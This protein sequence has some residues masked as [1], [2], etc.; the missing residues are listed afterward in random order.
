MA[1]AKRYEMTNK[2]NPFLRGDDLQFKLR[3][4]RPEGD[5]KRIVAAR[6]APIIT[7]PKNGVIQT[8]NETAQRMIENYHAPTN[9]KRNGVA[10]PPGAM[11][12]DVTATTA[13]E[14]VD[15]DLDTILI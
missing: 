13:P 8:T 12:E 3:Y 14:D 4:E 1:E 7:C 9:T 5:S 10:R 2:A 11:F 6:N 15:V